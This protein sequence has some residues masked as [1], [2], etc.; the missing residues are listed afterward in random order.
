MT[1]YSNRYLVPPGS[2]VLLN[3]QSS[4]AEGLV[5]WWPLRDGSSVA[6]DRS[7][8]GYHVVSDS[9][10]TA[11]P[12]FGGSSLVGAAT[13]MGANTGFSDHI[14]VPVHLRF[15]TDNN[16]A[17]SFWYYRGD[18]SGEDNAGNVY[19]NKDIS[20]SGT[21][22]IMRDSNADEDTDGKVNFGMRATGQTGQTISGVNLAA[23][24]WHFQTN[25]WNGVTRIPH[26]YQDG[27]LAATGTTRAAGASFFAGGMDLHIGISA[28]GGL[29]HWIGGLCDL[30]VYK[31]STPF[32]DQQVYEMWHPHSRWDLYAPVKRYFFSGLPSITYISPFVA[33]RRP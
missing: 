21:F 1:K 12:V 28:N 25:V 5:A 22:I 14:N 24:I 33:S 17:V 32:T 16:W 30:R 23:R 26:V 13:F 29:R 27:L 9:G 6:W 18:M 15:T 2:N 8:Y 11:D 3:H 7:G 19:E 31:R 4:Q 10:E 20:G